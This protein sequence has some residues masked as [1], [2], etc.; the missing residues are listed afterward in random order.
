[1]Q[2]GLLVVLGLLAVG[3]L[4]ELTFQVH[5]L[6]SLSGISLSP[7]FSLSAFVSHQLPL[8]HQIT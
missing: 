2:R 3:V 4:G 8:V 1:M 7:L 6:T 5:L